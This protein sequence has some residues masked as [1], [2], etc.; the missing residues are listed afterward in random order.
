MCIRLFINLIEFD[1]T[2][3]LKSILASQ[4]CIVISHVYTCE[5]I[6][7]PFPIRVDNT[8]ETCDVSDPKFLVYETIDDLRR[9]RL[10]DIS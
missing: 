5:R 6:H 2:L 9:D 7:D 4:P 8:R 3:Q 1:F 10:I